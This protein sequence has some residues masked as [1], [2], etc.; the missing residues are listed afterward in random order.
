MNRD[1]ENFLLKRLVLGP[2]ATNCFLLS[3]TQTKEAV[4][5]APAEASTVL[6]ELIDGN[7]INLKYIFNTH[8]HGDHIG[9]NKILKEK[10]SAKLMV[11]RLDED[12][13]IDD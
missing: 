8:G 4:I 2:L 5:I 3:C 6:L 1:R 9:G 7:E 13:L 10:Y 12:M 11:L